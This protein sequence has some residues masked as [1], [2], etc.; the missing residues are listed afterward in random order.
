MRDIK[1]TTRFQRDYKRENSKNL[2]AQLMAVVNLLAVEHSLAGQEF[3][4]PTVRRVER[5][6]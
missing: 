3:R 1:Y 6:S 2:N 5:S 4:S